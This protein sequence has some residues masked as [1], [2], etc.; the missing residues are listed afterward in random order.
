MHGGGGFGARRKRLA[1]PH[2]KVG[3]FAA[4][5]HAGAA[6]TPDMASA[7]P[8]LAVAAALCGLCAP[9][10]AGPLLGGELQRNGALSHHLYVPSGAAAVLDNR[11]GAGI[12][13]GLKGPLR[14]QLG[15]A[16]PAFSFSVTAKTSLSVLAVPGKGAALVLQTPVQ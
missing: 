14:Q 10:F 9:S 1:T 12:A 16:A 11:V 3:Q 2:T 13:L 7:V 8:A 4:F 6:D 5:R 15:A